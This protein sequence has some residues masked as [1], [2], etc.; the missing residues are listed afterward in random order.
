MHYFFKTEVNNLMSFTIDTL[1]MNNE[2]KH[3]VK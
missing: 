3:V 1:N 2:V